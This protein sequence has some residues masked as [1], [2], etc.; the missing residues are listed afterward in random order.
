MFVINVIFFNESK[1]KDIWGMITKLKLEKFTTFDSLEMDCS[2]G[3]NIIV[4]ANGTGKTHILKTIYSACEI[5]KSKKSFAEKLN[6]VFLPSKELIGRLVKR[7]SVSSSAFAEVHRVISLE[8]LLSSEVKLRLSF[9]NHTKQASKAKISGSPK[10]WINHEIESVYIPVKEMLSNAPGFRS[11]YASRQIAFEEI[12]SDIIDRALL[13]NLKGPVDSERKKILNILQ[14]AMDGKVTVDNEEFFLRNKQGKLEFTLLAE[15][16]RKL[17]LI[18]VLIQ[19]GTLLNGS[20]LF[21]DEPEANL[22]PRLMRTV[23]EILLELQR[24][25]VQIF[26]TTH[27]YVL[28]KEFDLQMKPKDKVM[29]HSLYRDNESDSVVLN[30]TTDYLQITPNVIDDTFA[31]LIDRDLEDI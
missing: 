18:W 5:T 14:K 11:L 26:L 27:D 20:V 13:P 16:I 7:S 4:G 15:G 9:S 3:I 10:Q 19:N 6:K 12:Y 23:V 29:F 24:M 25:G 30:S 2:K 31:D 28:L 21:W 22:N 17:A 8:S 1:F